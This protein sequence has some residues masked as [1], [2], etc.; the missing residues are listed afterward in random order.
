MA[1]TSWCIARKTVSPAPGDED[2]ESSDSPT[3]PPAKVSPDW[4]V[5][6]PAPVGPTWLQTPM[7]S[8]TWGPFIQ[9]IE[10][11]VSDFIQWRD[12]ILGFTGC[13]HQCRDPRD[14]Q[15]SIV[16]R[17]KWVAKAY[18]S[19]IYGRSYWLPLPP[20]MPMILGREP[21]HPDVKVILWW[22]PIRIDGKLRC[23]PTEA[24]GLV[25]SVYR[26]TRKI[27]WQRH[28][29]DP[30]FGANQEPEIHEVNE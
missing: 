30:A 1:R 4:L 17:L 12:W 22:E 23:W 7:K 10:K 8:E 13:M 2:S 19:V 29:S 5:V 3:P 28:S 24:A 14:Q 26:G 9:A 25:A 21:G 18:R 27:S 20:T 16:W 6:R 15:A 11:R